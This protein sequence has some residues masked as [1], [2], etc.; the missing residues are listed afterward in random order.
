MLSSLREISMWDLLKSRSVRS[1]LH[2]DDLPCV[3]STW[4]NLLVSFVDGFSPCIALV[5]NFVFS[6][7][8][9]YVFF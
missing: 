3:T 4:A 1:L 9:D 8:W 6:E 5:F 7:I 2:D